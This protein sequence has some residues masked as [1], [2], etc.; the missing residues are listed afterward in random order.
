ML[1]F[2]KSCAW[3]LSWEW[4]RAESCLQGGA[5]QLMLGGLRAGDPKTAPIPQL[6]QTASQLLL[7]LLWLLSGTISR[8]LWGLS[9]ALS[10]GW[11]SSLRSTL[12][13]MLSLSLQ[14]VM[15]SSCIGC[16]CSSHRVLSWYSCVPWCPALWDAYAI[17]LGE[18]QR[19]RII[20]CLA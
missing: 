16:K 13:C 17:S 5:W 6:S 1:G 18:D 19:S 9:Y 20:L 3:L 15:L 10:P 11:Q 12:S 7:G 2:G 4:I 8:I 14:E